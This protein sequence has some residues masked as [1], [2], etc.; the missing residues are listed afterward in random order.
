MVVEMASLLILKPPHCKVK[1][2][3]C[4]QQK[5]SYLLF[6]KK[7]QASKEA[8]DF[9]VAGAVWHQQLKMTTTNMGKMVPQK[10]DT[11][12]IETNLF[13]VVWL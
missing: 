9:K 13:Y 5:H 1:A 8:Q 6:C 3:G 7:T 2:V 12:A 11:K 10:H 4:F